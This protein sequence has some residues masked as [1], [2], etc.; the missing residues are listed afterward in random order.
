MP[1][2][3]VRIKTN[4]RARAVYATGP[5][6]R[7]E[8]V[9]IRELSLNGALVDQLRGHPDQTLTLLTE[10]SPARQI[11]LQGDLVRRS[12]TKG[13]AVHFYYSDR[14]TTSALWHYI[15]A[16]LQQQSTSHCPYCGNEG[17]A[18]EGQ[19]GQCRQSLAFQDADYL[20]VHLL[21]T[22]AARIQSRI[23]KLN[24]DHCHKIIKYIDRELLNLQ[25]RSTDQEFVGTCPTMLRVFSMINK[26]AGTD[27]NVLILG[28]SGTGKELTARA[29]HQRSPRMDKPFVA[30]NCAAI[31]EGL[32]EAELFGYQRGSFTGAVDTKKGKFELADGGTIFLDEIGDLSP[33]LQAKL[34]RFLED[35]I[36]ERIGSKRGHRVDVRIIAATNCDIHQRLEN[37]GF[38]DDLFFRLN[39]FC[40]KL[41]PLRER[42]GDKVVL[43]RYI[44]RK[45]SETGHF[46]PQGFSEEA[47]KAIS[48]HDWPGNVREL[49]NKIRRAM[50]MAGSDLLEPADLELEPPAPTVAPTDLHRQVSKSK[51]EIVL[52]ALEENNYVIARTARSLGI[53]RPSLYSMMKKFKIEH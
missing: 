2:L 49:I 51:K 7:E 4:L 41:P 9:T 8:V 6:Q 34:L 3:D 26:V 15:S 23:P 35:R 12:G 31:P 17:N 50:V 52:A 11:R 18:A 53:S 25:D 42:G 13:S 22:L 39:A 45:I 20:D 48:R 32:L 10:L 37:G 43:A 44:F 1:R 36:V 29:I 27:L 38:R 19:C 28:E 24:A 16:Q 46:T 33:H 21:E 14:N 5:E 40:I 47:L 30:F